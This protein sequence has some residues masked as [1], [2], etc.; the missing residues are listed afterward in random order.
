MISRRRRLCTAHGALLHVDAVQAVGRGN[1]DWLGLGAASFA[2]S[3]HKFG[4]ADG[5]WG[6]V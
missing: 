5:G 2:L 4:G 6:A 3:G 1:Q